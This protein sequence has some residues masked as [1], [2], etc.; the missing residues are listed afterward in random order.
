MRCCTDAREACSDR[1]T[2]IQGGEEA[3]STRGARGEEKGLEPPWT[4]VCSDEP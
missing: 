1:E 3:G 4:E 2:A